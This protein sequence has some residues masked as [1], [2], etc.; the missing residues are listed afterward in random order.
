MANSQEGRADRRSPNREDIQNLLLPE[1]LHFRCEERPVDAG[2][3]KRLADAQ[4]DEP[5]IWKKDGV[6][7]FLFL[8]LGPVESNVKTFVWC[9]SDKRENCKR[10]GYRANKYSTLNVAEPLEFTSLLWVQMTNASLMTGTALGLSAE[11]VPLHSWANELWQLH[12]KTDTLV[13]AQHR[14]AFK[15]QI[16]NVLKSTAQLLQAKEAAVRRK[17]KLTS[18]ITQ[19]F[20]PDVRLQV[21]EEQIDANKEVIGSISP[22]FRRMLDEGAAMQEAAAGVVQLPTSS[23]GTVRS[24]LALMYTDGEALCNLKLAS[25]EL[26]DL[27]AQAAEWDCQFI[28]KKLA[29]K[30][31]IEIPS[32]CAEV[33]VQFLK[34]VS[35]HAAATRKQPWIELLDPLVERVAETRQGDL[36]TLLDLSMDTLKLVLKSDKLDTGDDEINVLKFSV[37]WS[38]QHGTEKL[39]EL[40]AAVR[41]PQ[42][43]ILQ[44]RPDGKAALHFARQHAEAKLKTLLG[45]ATSI[46]LGVKRAADFAEDPEAMQRAQ[47]RQRSSGCVQLKPDELGEMLC[48]VALL[49]QDSEEALP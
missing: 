36:S 21:E 22:F 25:T 7:S 10:L 9:V 14:D 13:Y 48:R 6:D 30:L 8:R 42:L 41:F 11:Q 20:F 29:Q 12:A 47:K 18:R 28:V 23:T 15:M 32:L 16:R 27:I 5:P 40:I 33:A 1:I 44:L 19:S 45:E 49:G 2:V 24:M 46:Q 3:Y 31:K 39:P 17:D 43:N 38:K 26:V 4:Q 34:L 35:L 37:K